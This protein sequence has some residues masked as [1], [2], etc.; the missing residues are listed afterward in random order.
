MTQKWPEKITHQEAADRINDAVKWDTDD[1]QDN[2]CA[3]CGKPTKTFVYLW[4]EEDDYNG[5]GFPIGSTYLKKVKALLDKP[6]ADDKPAS[7]Q[8][9]VKFIMLTLGCW[10]AGETLDKAKANLKEAG[11]TLRESRVTYLFVSEVP[12][13]DGDGDAV[14]YID[15][16]GGV[17]WKNCKMFKV[18][19]HT[20]KKRR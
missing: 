8:T 6:K 2:T 1:S 18:E 20:V 7:Q 15:G 12:F 3:C 4:D 10:G 16:Y 19:K 9:H 11:G 14:A 5:D 17:S 13:G